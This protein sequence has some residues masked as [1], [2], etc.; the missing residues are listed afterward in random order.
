[1]FF[2]ILT[3]WKGEIMPQTIKVAF[4]HYQGGSYSQAEDIC[5]HILNQDSESMAA[6][7]LVGLISM[8]RGDYLRAIQ[9][10]DKA[11]ALQPDNNDVMMNLFFAHAQLGNELMC[12]EKFENA[13]FHLDKAASLQDTNKAV[14]DNIF[15]SCFLFGTD[16]I[17]RHQFEDAILYLGRAKSI[18]PNSKDVINNLFIAHA[19]LG[20]KFAQTGTLVD[21]I[22][23]LHIAYNLNPEVQEVAHNLFVALL[24]LGISLSRQGDYSEAL[25]R[26][27]MAYGLGTKNPHLFATLVAT[28]CFSHAGQGLSLLGRGENFEATMHL[29]R[30]STIQPEKVSIYNNLFNMNGYGTYRKNMC[31]S[32]Y[33]PCTSHKAKPVTPKSLMI[34]IMSYNNG[35]HLHLAVASAKY[36]A[37]G[38]YI[39]IFDDNS[40][41]HVTVNVIK[42][43][44]D[45]LH[46][47]YS[48]RKIKDKF[49]GRLYDNMNLAVDTAIKLG[50]DY[51]LFVQDDQQ[52]V[53][54]LDAEFYKDITNIFTHDK[55]IAE[56]SVRFF[57]NDRY[58]GSNKFIYDVYN[59]LYYQPGDHMFKMVDVGIFSIDRLNERGFRFIFDETNYGMLAN[60]L[61]MRL[62]F[63]KNPVITFS[64]WP[65]SPKNDP[66]LAQQYNPGVHPIRYMTDDEVRLFC[67]RPGSVYPVAEKFLEAVEP[68]RQ[69]WWFLSINS[70]TIESLVEHCRFC[71]DTLTIPS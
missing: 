53:R 18:H 58:E 22:L 71:P 42:Q 45:D 68:I 8:K 12:E 15:T 61:G 36:S 23:H 55:N 21:A 30:I 66:N 54:R 11:F 48:E 69:N 4:D 29:K 67:S 70:S 7:F 39:C 17:R 63:Y 32:T 9:F 51:I 13:L 65:S 25:L 60:E 57:F 14:L 31:V 38:V 35:R 6:L 33:F 52:F 64:P 37:S 16:F 43:L 20:N 46:I 5:L 28:L 2:N 3:S 19:M 47:F 40:D 10:L 49:T 62:C 56:V 41:C 1:M 44:S 27:E 26:L 24:K 34:A 59:R 50:F